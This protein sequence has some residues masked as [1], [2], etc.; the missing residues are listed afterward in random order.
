[1]RTT[2]LILLSVFLLI[3]FA[4]ASQ[5][6]LAERVRRQ[7]G[8][9]EVII[10]NEYSPADLPDLVKESDLIARVL[11]LDSGRSRL[12]KDEQSMDSEFTVQ[13]L[14]Q[15]FSAR[16]LGLGE[17]LVVTKPGGTM[18][19]E[20]Y[21]VTSREPGF[22]PFQANEEY[23]LFL[24]VDPSTGQYLVPY[25]AQ[26]AFRNVGGAVE[27]VAKGTPIWDREMGRVPFVDFAQELT[28]ILNPR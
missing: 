27:Q 10:L 5:E 20:E 2:G 12:T 14:E 28:R 3:S 24:K 15:F 21:S 23:I 26:G 16:P 9:L 6:T 7:H 18:T 1:M 19:I 8:A 11:V 25:G 17:K 13:V 4:D 22:P